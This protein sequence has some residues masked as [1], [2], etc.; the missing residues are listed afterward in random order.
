MKIHPEILKHANDSMDAVAKAV[1]SVQP[2]ITR[3][4][5]DGRA[6]KYERQR[7]VAAANLALASMKASAAVFRMPVDVD[8][9]PPT[10]KVDE[11]VEL[12]TEAHELATEAQLQFRAPG[13]PEITAL[14]NGLDLAIVKTEVAMIMYY[15]ANGG[16]SQMK[17]EF[18]EA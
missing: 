2:I 10:A 7:V 17:D 8:H 4:I 6:G 11:I 18:G 9:L 3:V 16:P 15:Q 12:L 13:R 5:T 14:V 1:D